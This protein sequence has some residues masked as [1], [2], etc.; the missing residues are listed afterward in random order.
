MT[1]Y[2]KVLRFYGFFKES[3]TESINES[4]RVRK[5]H[6]FFYLEDGS[7]SGTEPKLS[8]SGIPQGAF[9]NRQKV[10]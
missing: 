6:I 3:I 1:E 5:L 2:L 10:Y 4:Y 7:I 9:L 8:N